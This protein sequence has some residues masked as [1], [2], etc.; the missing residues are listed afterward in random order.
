MISSEF[1]RDGHLNPKKP[2]GQRLYKIYAIVGWRGSLKMITVLH[3]G[4][5]ANDYGVPIIWGKLRVP[6]W[7]KKIRY[8]AFDR[9]PY[10]GGVSRE[11]IR[12]PLYQSRV[13]Q[14]V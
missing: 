3:R 8:V 13:A 11:S 14:I 10:K 12:G 4:G 7:R 6:P 9:L 5:R 2:Q 1:I